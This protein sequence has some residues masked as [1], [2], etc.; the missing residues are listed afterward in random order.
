MELAYNEVV[1]NFRVCNICEI[2]FKNKNANTHSNR[3][4]FAIN[5]AVKCLTVTISRLE[6]NFA[7]TADYNL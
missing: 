4:N 5:F 6:F 2:E 1:C 3:V 7:I